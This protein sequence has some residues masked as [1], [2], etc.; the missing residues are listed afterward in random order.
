MV[1]EDKN[2]FVLQNDKSV[3]ASPGPPHL[4]AG[5]VSLLLSPLTPVSFPRQF[6]MSVGLTISSF[7]NLFQIASLQTEAVRLPIIPQIRCRF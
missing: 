7:T 3:P 1:M 4:T 6:L 2:W 5:P